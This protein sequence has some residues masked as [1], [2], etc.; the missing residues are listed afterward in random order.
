MS[1]EKKRR[2]FADWF[3]NSLWGHIVAFQV[4]GA[5]PFFVLFLVFAYRAG[6][7]SFSSIVLLLTASIVFGILAAVTL[8]FLVTRRVME[9][10]GD[11]YKRRSAREDLR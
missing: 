10:Y 2:T 8:W 11:A 5:L 1:D 4:V 9:K 6:A 7:L 3:R